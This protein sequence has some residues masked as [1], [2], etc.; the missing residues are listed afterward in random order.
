MRIKLNEK[1]YQNNEESAWII[2]YSRIKVDL[3]GLNYRNI[4]NRFYIHN[5]DRNV[6][7][8][9][10]SSTDKCNSFL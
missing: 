4:Q 10:V 6:V 7:M 1:N 9:R 2:F 8:R 5:K 3:G